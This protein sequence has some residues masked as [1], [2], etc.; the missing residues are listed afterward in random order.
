MSGHSFHL[1][2]SKCNNWL[3]KAE[4]F[5]P[6]IIYTKPEIYAFKN[7]PGSYPNIRIF[8]KS[9][10]KCSVLFSIRIRSNVLYLEG[11]F[12]RL[13]F[14]SL[15][16]SEEESALVSRTAAGN[17]AY[18][19]IWWDCV[20]SVKLSK[21]RKKSWPHD[22]QRST[23]YE[24]RGVWLADDHKTLSPMFD[25]SSQSKQKLVLKL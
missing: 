9:Q 6:Y 10:A 4:I 23:F 8:R 22:A 13:D 16:R 25:I 3:S 1:M 15:P 20:S 24:I 5:V 17:R 18:C 21:N 11:W 12:T 7:S 14:C 2:V 19:F